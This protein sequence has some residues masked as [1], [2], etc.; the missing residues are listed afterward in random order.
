MGVGGLRKSGL[1]DPAG[2]AGQVAGNM[3]YEF[4]IKRPLLSA[5]RAPSYLRGCSSL[6]ISM[7]VVG[8]G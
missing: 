8:F 1:A 3:S 2:R 5:E 6:W 7:L 4:K